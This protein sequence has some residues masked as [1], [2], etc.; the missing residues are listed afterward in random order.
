MTP[1]SV[2]CQ[3]PLSMGLSRQEYWS[4]LPYPSPEDLP[5][6]GIEPSFPALA[7]GFISCLTNHY[8][9]RQHSMPEWWV[10][11][12]LPTPTFPEPCISADLSSESQ[13]RR[14]SQKEALFA[15]SAFWMFKRPAFFF[16]FNMTRSLSNSD[17][18]H[19]SR[20]LGSS[21]LRELFWLDLVFTFFFFLQHRAITW[22]SFIYP[23]TVWRMFFLPISSTRNQTSFIFSPEIC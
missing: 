21:G 7:G 18:L 5:D 23:L 1:W 4:G 13:Q 17:L 2:A 6:P 20:N 11:T 12:F 22:R 14:A 10:P 9:C 19:C 3:A 8:T 15:L 16:F